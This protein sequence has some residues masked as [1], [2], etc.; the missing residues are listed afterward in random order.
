M[1]NP[2]ISAKKRQPAAH[3]GGV[4][5]DNSVLRSS[6]FEGRFG[7][8]FRSL[9]SAEWP[10]K[11]LLDLGLAMTADPEHLDTDKNA[12]TAAFE[13]DDK[14]IQDDEENV[15]IA[16]GYTYLGQFIDHDITF[17]P[18]SSLQQQNDPDALID[19]RTP[20]LDLDSLYGRGPGDQPWM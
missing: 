14:R 3:G 5:G 1:I 7:R 20:R 10:K 19:F 9:P 17:D 8:M 16:A 11:A 13:A 18:A 12:P 6:Q 2:A 15:A 4:R